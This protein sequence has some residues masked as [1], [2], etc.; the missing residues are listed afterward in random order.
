MP[1]IKLG[2]ERGSP[3]DKNLVDQLAKELKSSTESGQ[4]LIYEHEL[5]RDRLR[6]IVIWDAWDRVPLADRTEIIL[7]AYDIAEGAASRNKIA[8]A[9]GLTVPEATEA[10]RLP[11]QISTA[12]RKGD[13]VTFQQCRDAMLAEGASILFGPNV[14]QLRFAAQKEAEACRERLLKRLPGSEN[15]WLINREIAVQDTITVEDSAQIKKH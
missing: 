3:A 11:Y 14:L 10:G 8:L 12:L 6:V 1:R 2:P 5:H 9:S 7:R 15:V 13:P 4:P